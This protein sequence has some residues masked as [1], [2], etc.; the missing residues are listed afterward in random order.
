MKRGYLFTGNLYDSIQNTRT[1]WDSAKQKVKGG[2]FISHKNEDKE[3]SISIAY[4]I[5]RETLTPCYVDELDPNMKGDSAELVTY[6][7][8]VI[9]QCGSMLAIISN[10]TVNSWWVPLEIGIAL[11]TKKYI[12][13][14]KIQGVKLPSYLWSWPIMFTD[15]E[16]VEWAN[17]I[18]KDFD[19][20]RFHRAWRRNSPSYFSDRSSI[21]RNL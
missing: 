15:V 16:A 10:H 21:F 13:S 6:I 2:I 1:S 17:A 18:K 4:K 12:G 9:H 11:E 19:A 8:D 7:Q 14:Y 3:K 20:D 5:A